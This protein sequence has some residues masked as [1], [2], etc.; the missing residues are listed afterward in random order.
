MVCIFFVF[1]L[2][3]VLPDSSETDYIPAHYYSPLEDPLPPRLFVLDYE[4]KNNLVSKIIGFELLT[5]EDV[6]FFDRS[7]NRLP[8]CFQPLTLEGVINPT[9]LPEV[10]ANNSKTKQWFMKIARPTCYAWNVNVNSV[11]RMMG[12]PKLGNGLGSFIGNLESHWSKM[13]EFNDRTRFSL[14]RFLI[15]LP[16]LTADIQELAVKNRNSYLSWV[17]AQLSKDHFY[18]QNSVSDEKIASEIKLVEEFLELK[19][20]EAEEEIERKKRSSMNRYNSGPVPP[21]GPGSIAS[22]ITPLLLPNSEKPK[23]KDMNK[24]ESKPE[25][26]ADKT[27]MA[28]FKAIETLKKIL[29]PNSDPSKIPEASQLTAADQALLTPILS[30]LH[31]FFDSFSTGVKR[32]ID[33]AGSMFQNLRNQPLF[34]NLLRD[35]G[36]E[37]S[38]SKLIFLTKLPDADF[39]QSI[40]FII[41]Y[42]FI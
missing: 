17:D 4:C 12:N 32:K 24:S 42:S 31:H 41:N 36:Y 25:F 29:F 30:S 21:Y 6:E 11:S 7:N 19:R 14:H 1:F 2:N 23:L 28:K 5:P 22:R 40:K 38:Q 33:T 18:S 10:Y 9:P 37:N 8:K 16:E 35:L 3:L 13:C 26:F 20:K 27:Q 15:E 34:P 39:F